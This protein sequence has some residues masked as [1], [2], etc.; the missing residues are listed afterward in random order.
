MPYMHSQ[1]ELTEVPSN[2][3]LILSEAKSAGND[4][5]SDLM[6][7]ALIKQKGLLEHGELHKTV[8]PEMQTIDIQGGKSKKSGVVYHPLEI[9][10]W[11]YASY[12]FM[13]GRYDAAERY[14]TR[15]IA[16]CYVHSNYVT[17][18]ITG[19]G[20]WSEFIACLIRNKKGKAAEDEYNKLLRKIEAL[21]KHDLQPETADFIR[22]ME[23]L[24]KESNKVKGKMDIQKLIEVSRKI[25]Y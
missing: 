9:I 10:A 16:V 2:Y 4:K 14:Y 15:A 8:D 21:M 25:T 3:L 11:K 19:I 24:L 17:M 20:I 12:L 5:L 13:K 7:D 22:K 6:Y 18:Q 23:L 1:K